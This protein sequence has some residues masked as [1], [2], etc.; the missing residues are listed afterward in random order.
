[1]LKAKKILQKQKGIAKALQ[2]CNEEIH[3]VGET[4]P[5]AR[6]VFCV[7]VVYAFLKEPQKTD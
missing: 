7:K 1:M 6:Q 2:K 4:L 3:L 5:K